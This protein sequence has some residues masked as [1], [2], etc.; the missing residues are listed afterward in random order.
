LFGAP[1]W[2]D[3]LQTIIRLKGSGHYLLKLP[4][5]LLLLKPIT[6][7]G[8]G[9]ALLLKRRITSTSRVIRMTPLP[10]FR[11]P[12]PGGMVDDHQ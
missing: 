3:A 5:H 12:E 2:F 4:R 6:G 8:T 11:L 1:F 7:R 10:G 9:G